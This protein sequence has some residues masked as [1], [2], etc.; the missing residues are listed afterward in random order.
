MREKYTFFYKK[1]HCQYFLKKIDVIIRQC[2][3]TFS[4]QSIYKEGFEP[5]VML[6]KNQAPMFIELF[7]ERYGDKVSYFVEMNARG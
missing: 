6:Q 4:L 2:G 3:F 5:Y 1:R 7:L